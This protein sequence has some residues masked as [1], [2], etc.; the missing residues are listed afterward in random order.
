MV[1]NIQK[2]ASS[3]LFNNKD[4]S[5]L[6]AKQQDAALTQSILSAELKAA[7]VKHKEEKEKSE[8]ELLKLNKEMMELKEEK[9]KLTEMMFNAGRLLTSDKH[10]IN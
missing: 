2:P 3:N 10:E 5:F 1:R 6:R 7:L 9:K 8:K 4:L